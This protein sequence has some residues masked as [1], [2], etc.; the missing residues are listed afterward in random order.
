VGT[1]FTHLLSWIHLEWIEK[2]SLAIPL[3]VDFP[4]FKKKSLLPSGKSLLKKVEYQTESLKKR[5]KK[6]C[7]IGLESLL[8][9]MGKEELETPTT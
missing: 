5:K 2:D 3:F 8:T 4:Q 7:Q 6:L 1:F 9:T